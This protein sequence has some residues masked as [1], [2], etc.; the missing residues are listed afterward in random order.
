M[1][2]KIS[3]KEA[4]EKGKLDEFIKEHEKDPCGDADAVARALQSFAARNTPENLT[5][6]I[7]K[8]KKDEG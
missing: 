5:T 6:N 2:K 3:L 4:R 7:K 1:S 8:T